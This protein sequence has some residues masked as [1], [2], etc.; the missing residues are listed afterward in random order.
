MLNKLAPRS[1][2]KELTHRSLATRENWCRI[3]QL[4]EVCVHTH[5]PHNPIL[6]FPLT[7]QF[8]K[9]LQVV[10]MLADIYI[11]SDCYPAKVRVV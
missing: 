7:N 10:V 8:C 5:P 9:T 3:F 4:A 11:S 6:L 1:N 2:E